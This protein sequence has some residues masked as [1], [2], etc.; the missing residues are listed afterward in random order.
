MTT[1]CRWATACAAVL[2]V[3]AAGCETTGGSQM[4]TTVYDMHRR[5]VKLDRELDSSVSRLNET[6][7]TLLAR[8][9]ES[10]QQTRMLR[11]LLEENQMKLEQLSRDLNSMKT[12]LYRHWNLT[13]AAPGAPP[14]DAA[15][16]AVTIEGAPTFTPPPAVPPQHELLDSA[17]VPLE[18]TPPPVPAPLETLEPGPMPAPV[19]EPEITQE[20]EYVSMAPATP[21]AP[22]TADPRLLYQQAQRSYANDDFNTAL[23]E[24]D[25]Y[26]ARFPSEDPSLTANALFWKAKCLMSLGRYADAVQA[27][28]SLRGAYSTSTKVPF[29]MHNQAV[30]HSRLG[31]TAQAERLMEAVIDQYPI[32]PA[33]DQARADLRKLRGE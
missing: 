15:A 12:T 19:S 4:Q 9:D 20:P 14:R 31:Q 22:G 29:A 33:A 23:R 26:L 1:K 8:V 21:T 10:D 17:P 30:A 24:F 13:T 16:G 18:R 27:F 5:M 28:E 3:I 2:I 6:T 32:S 11:G 7:A 25:E